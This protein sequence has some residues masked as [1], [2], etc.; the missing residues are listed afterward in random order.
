M[1]GAD[2]SLTTEGALGANISTGTGEALGL[3]ATAG[4]IGKAIAPAFKSLGAGWKAWTATGAADGA[5]YGATHRREGDL[6]LKNQLAPAGRAQDALTD[7]ATGAALGG[8]LGKAAEHIPDLATKL[9]QHSPNH[10]TVQKILAKMGYEQAGGMLPPRKTEDSPPWWEDIVGTIAKKY[11]MSQQDVDFL[12]GKTADPP[13]TKWGMP[14]RREFWSEGRRKPRVP[15][16]NAFLHAKDHAHKFGLNSGDPFY[17]QKAH[18]FRNNLPKGTELLINKASGQRIYYHEPSN[19]FLV[20]D[21]EG[22]I[23]SFYKPDE[24]RGWFTD[25]FKHGI[26]Y[27]VVK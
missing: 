2:P 24:G 4:A 17:I 15:L 25:Q 18:D 21:R 27:G 6:T 23:Q 13:A 7:A 12:T 11:N 22:R 16:N 26:Y 3:S 8:A 14:Y 20:T 10:P 19:R 5:I 1:L 9:L